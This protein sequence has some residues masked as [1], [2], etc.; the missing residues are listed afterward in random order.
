MTSKFS[1]VAL[2]RMNRSLHLNYFA[3]M[4]PHR[5]ACIKLSCIERNNEP[6]CVDFPIGCPNMDG[7]R[8]IE[9]ISIDYVSITDPS[10]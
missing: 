10:Y 1:L 8:P 5:Y 6:K 2:L 3:A 4:E 9:V 7:Y